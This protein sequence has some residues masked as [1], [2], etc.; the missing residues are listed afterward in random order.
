MSSAILLYNY[1]RIMQ[2][3]AYII[4]FYCGKISSFKMSTRPKYAFIFFFIA[5]DCGVKKRLVEIVVHDEDYEKAYKSSLIN[6]IQMCIQDA[7]CKAVYNSNG[8]CFII[9]LNAPRLIPYPGSSYFDKVCNI[10]YR[11]YDIIHKF[12]LSLVKLIKCL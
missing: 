10:T 8:F 1:L 2:R 3:F 5:L 4:K 6:C 9:Y 11:K 7:N 12:R